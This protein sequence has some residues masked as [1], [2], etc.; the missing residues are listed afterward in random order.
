MNAIIDAAF[1]RTRIVGL[2][3]LMTLAV[4]AY[5]YVSVPK[6]SL[7]EI[8]IPY[9]YV[10]T[11]L[12]GISP[13]DAERLLVE[14]MEIEF[15]PLTGLKKMEGSASEGYA[16]VMLEFEPG[17]DVDEALD[18]VREAADRVSPELPE[19]AT[20]PVVVETNTALFPILTAVLSGP[21]PERT[22][23]RIANELQDR[24]EAVGGVLE[25]DIGGER[26]EVLEVLI[27]PTVFE[28]YNISFEELIGQISRNNRLVAA[29]TI[30]SGAGR[31]V[32]KVPGLIE[33][34]D[35]VMSLPVKVRGDTVVTFSDVAT[36]RRTFEDSTG[37]AR[38]D[39]QP[40]LALEVKK[41]AGSNVIGTVAAVKAVIEEEAA[42][43]PDSVTVKYM[44]DESE[45]VKTM[46]SDL[47]S[48]VIAAIV[49][50]MIVVV[51]ALGL[52]SAVLVGL[53]IPGAFLAGV[54][55][56][57]FMG[58][59]MNI[60]VLFSLILV[61][62]M[63]VDG[64]I[65]T[66]ELADRKLQE[67]A[68]P[69]Q[70]YAL[71]AKR[72]AW[73]IIASTLT[74]LSVFFPLLFWTGM[75]GEF[76]KYLP[77]TVIVTLTASLFMALVFIPVMGGLI[78]RKQPQTAEDKAK[79]HAAEFGD[80]RDIGGLTGGYVRMLQWAILRPWT[81]LTLAFAFLLAG[82][83]AY[84][85]FG[86]GISFFPSIEPD[87]M[88]VEVRA[89][90]NFSIYEKDALVRRVE[91]RLYERNDIA[92]VYAR[93][94]S[95]GAGSQVDEEVI[96]TI[97]LELTEWDTRGT[98]AEIGE[99]I[100][101]GMSDIAGIDVQMQIEA[102]G[103]SSGK[104]LSLQIRARD[105]DTQAAVAEDVRATMD[106]IGGFTDVVDTR[107]LPGVEWRIRVNRS[108]AA[109]FGAD[110][111]LLGQAIQLL[112]Q[113]VT[114]ADYRPDDAEG[115]LDIRVRFPAAERT[116][117]ELQS[118]RVPT[119][120]GLVPISNFVTFEPSPRTGTIKRVDQRRVTTIE[121]NV[122]PGLLVSDQITELRSALDRMDLPEGV[123]WSF[124]GEAQD[125]QDAMT[126]LTGAFISAIVLMFA[127]LVTQFNSFYQAF[128]VMSAIVFSIAGVLFGLIVTGRPFGVV[129]GGI[130]VI[131]LAGI[132]VNNNIVLID[133]YNDLKRLGQSPLEAALRTGAQRLRPVVLTSATT[134]LALMPMV[135]G[136][137]I[138]FF[139]RRIIYGAPSTQLWTEL[140]AAIAGGLLIA[141]I[142]TLIVTP[143]M[144][145]LGEKR[146]TRAR[147]TEIVHAEPA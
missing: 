27:D 91:E 133:T 12:D 88:Q 46:L 93:S 53:S 139:N 147:P 63:L 59:T 3:L 99:Q 129:M 115:T 57:W 40:A 108:E 144:L 119:S 111:S 138:D 49:L 10:F 102:D 70:A 24:I 79:R 36:I 56:L 127:V 89:R 100:R 9:V 82:F 95:G 8:S 84:G 75:M 26:T 58:Y 122:A 11:T 72:M 47:E 137:N 15:G 2:T 142:L 143:A 18:R 106:R 22:L 38:I 101:T 28:T 112:T 61:V 113:G 30:E 73:P 141:T 68:R 14:P 126:F 117:E 90:D 29:G 92:S 69:R 7:P 31:I 37:F 107:P 45:Q 34:I 25:V 94:T 140:S 78:G 52:R 76:M 109:R 1:S 146:A 87:F 35:D 55:V 50:V 23:N 120:A 54:A 98:A 60:V 121:S 145:M 103:P 125:Q 42:A 48:N 32:L 19:D 118:L 132:V 128:V 85:Q 20:E 65:I 77:I 21:V 44:Q 62:G 130:A 83:G 105:S 86:S 13:E 134:A 135:I 110:V 66:T 5:A 123:D 16:S 136:L 114:V 131:A 51:W 6:E 74:T 124:A 67:G 43:W 104:P 39:R 71:A 64:A 80:P 4:G 116:L 33:D 17:G 97:Q 96:G 81:T 41:R